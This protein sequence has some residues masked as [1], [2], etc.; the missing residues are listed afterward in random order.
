MNYSIEIIID[1]KVKEPFMVV[2]KNKINDGSIVLNVYSSKDGIIDFKKMKI[3]SFG[4]DD[5]I[6]TI[7]EEFRY[8]KGILENAYLIT[9]KPKTY[10]KEINEKI[11]EKYLG[12]IHQFIENNKKLSENSLVIGVGTYTYDDNS[13][14]YIEQFKNYEKAF[15]L[16]SNI[17]ELCTADTILKCTNIVK[18]IVDEVKKHPKLSQLE[19]AMFGYDL[20]RTNMAKTL[21]NDSDEEKDFNSFADK[22]LEPSFFY[23]PLYTEILRRLNINT[24]TGTGYFNG[25]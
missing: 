9:V 16:M 19:K 4:N 25:S 8:G 23:A 14:K 7:K 10:E 20:L 15:F 6:E 13:K 22:F 1:E 21:E 5:I 11:I 18:D 3:F 24:L 2:E 17:N 12:Y